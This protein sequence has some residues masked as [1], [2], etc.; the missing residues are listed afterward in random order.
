[1]IF[2]CCTG[3]SH[4]RSGSYCVCDGGGCTHARLKDVKKGIC[5]AHVVSLHLA[6]SLLMF[7]PFSPLSS[8]NFF[9]TARKSLT[10]TELLPG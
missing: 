10:F 9:D 4:P 3:V 5:S 1:M 8:D 7:H 6:F 2:F